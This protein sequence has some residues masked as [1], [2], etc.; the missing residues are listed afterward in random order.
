MK[1]EHQLREHGCYLDAQNGSSAIVCL[2]PERMRQ[3]DSIV[4]PPN[5]SIMFPECAS[6]PLLK[7]DIPQGRAG[8]VV[9]SSPVKNNNT[10]R[11]CRN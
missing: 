3:P 8:C 9:P 4:T 2:S 1:A 5:S 10:T 7:T 11:Q 6:V